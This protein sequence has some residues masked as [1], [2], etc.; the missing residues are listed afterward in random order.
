MNDLYNG[1]DRSIDR[2]LEKIEKHLQNPI[3]KSFFE[4][5]G[6]LDLLKEV[7]DNPTDLLKKKLDDTFREFYF[8]IRFTTYLSQ[9]IYF[10]AINFDKKIKLFSERN[11]TILD[12]PLKG[13]HEGT[14]IDVLSSAEW[15][16]KQDV[17][18]ASSDISDHLTSDSLFYGAQLLTDNQRQLLS[19]AYIYG[20]NDSE[21]AVYL[22]KSQQA[23]SRSHKK[24]LSKLREVIE[25]DREGRGLGD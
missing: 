22:N 12:K 18:P 13:D 2:Y 21:I 11:L 10:N 19:L 1:Y 20:L 6:N 8:K 5:P 24:A 16:D 14:L 17:F 3:I 9:A 23:V 7:I 4:A 25:I 15:K